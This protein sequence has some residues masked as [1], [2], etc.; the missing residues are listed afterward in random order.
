MD[1]VD[2][3]LGG[4]DEDPPDTKRGAIGLETQK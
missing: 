2:D 3:E 1:V 4:I